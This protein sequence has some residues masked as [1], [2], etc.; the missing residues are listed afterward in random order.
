MDDHLDEKRN[1]TDGSRLSEGIHRMD[2]VYIFFLI[3]FATILEIGGFFEE[4]HILAECQIAT[5][6]Q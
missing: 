6:Q 2:M 3:Y 5:F 4:V 1:R